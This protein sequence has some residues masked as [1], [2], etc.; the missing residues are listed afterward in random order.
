MYKIILHNLEYFLFLHILSA[1]T[2]GYQLLT[3]RQHEEERKES[4]CFL[5][6][7]ADTSLGMQNKFHLIPKTD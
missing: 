2:T 5:L 7:L 1:T 3:N 6:E 4:F